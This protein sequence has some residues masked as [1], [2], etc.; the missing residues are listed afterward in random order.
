MKHYKS[1]VTVEQWLKSEGI[2]KEPVR[3][4]PGNASSTN[5]LTASNRCSN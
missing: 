2:L 3:P 4:P 5:R 1:D